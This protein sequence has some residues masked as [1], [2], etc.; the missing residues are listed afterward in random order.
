M[1]QFAVQDQKVALDGGENQDTEGDQ[2]PQGDPVQRDLLVN[3]D[4]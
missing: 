3:M 4:Q 1:K 2:V